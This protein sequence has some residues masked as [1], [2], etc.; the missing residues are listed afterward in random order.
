MTSSIDWTRRALAVLTANGM[1]PDKAGFSSDVFADMVAPTE[2]LDAR[3]AA[4]AYAVG[5]GNLGSIL[6]GLVALDRGISRAAACEMLSVII[7]E[8]EEGI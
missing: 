4:L 5:M 3:E 2:G 7:A 8:V 6:L 1:A